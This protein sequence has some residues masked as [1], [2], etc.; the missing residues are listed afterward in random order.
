M[1]CS[2]T[3]CQKKGAQQFATRTTS[4]LEDAV[5]WKRGA[6]VE[7]RALQ[8]TM[9]DDIILHFSKQ[10]STPTP[11]A[12]GLRDRIQKRAL[13]TQKSFR[14]YS[15]QRGIETMVSDYGPDHGVGVDPSLLS[16]APTAPQGHK[17]R[18]TIWKTLGKILR[19][20][21]ELR[22]ALQNPRRDPAEASEKPS[23]RQISSEILGEGC[24][25]Q[26]VT[27]RNFRNCTG[28]PIRMSHILPSRNHRRMW[29]LVS[30]STL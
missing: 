29:L 23:E 20:P 11:W 27:L 30:S 8:R 28:S 19:T 13:Q 12:R 17:H 10:G 4:K 25:P 5:A 1:F 3:A 21:G 2:A 16:I 7:L 24:A 15:A 18:V 14:V 6:I 26:M 22:R 9:H